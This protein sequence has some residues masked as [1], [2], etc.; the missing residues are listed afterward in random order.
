M[1]IREAV[2][3]DNQS[4]IELQRKCPMGTDLLLQLDSSPDFFNRSRGYE[5]WHVLVAKEE[6]MLLGAAGYTVQDKPIGGESY[7]LVYEYGFMVDPGA[8]RR[9]IASCLQIEIE[10]RTADSDVMHLNIIEGNTASHNFFTGRG[11]QQVKGCVP[12]MVMAYREHTV[13][14]FKIRRMREKDIPVVVDLLNETYR[15]YELYNEMTEDSFREYYGRLPFYNMDDIYLYEGDT[16]LAVA[17]VWDYDKVMK[18][19]LMGFDTKWKLMRMMTNFMGLFTAMPRIPDVGEEM[20]NWYLTPIGFRDTHAANQ[21]LGYLLN[22]AYK[23][24]VGMIN[25]PMDGDSHVKEIR[26]GYRHGTGS[27]FWYMKPMSG[28]ELPEM[29]SKPMYVDIRDI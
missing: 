9:G 21:L 25:L 6:G 7:S 13:D 10:K 11:F 20:T 29:G 3:D 15:G 28:K 19:K 2:Q 22:M 16:V 8:R 23:Q 24:N 4:L 18:F 14:K 26:S 27:F 5:N 1:N 17:G 12:F